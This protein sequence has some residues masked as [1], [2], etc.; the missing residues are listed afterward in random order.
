WTLTVL[1]SFSYWDMGS[2]EPLTMDAAGNLYG[3]TFREGVYGCGS[4]FKL[5]RSGSDWT[6]RSLHDFTCGSDAG[7]PTSNVTLREGVYGCGSVFKLTRSGSDWT[8][9]SLHDFTSGSDA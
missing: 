9:R 4:V 5:T 7:W 2:V 6:Y 1:H 8:Y 3:T